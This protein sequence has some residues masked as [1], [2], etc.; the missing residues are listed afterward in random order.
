MNPRNVW[1]AVVLALGG[2]L[3]IGGMAVLK[4]DRDL[5][6]LCIVSF[7]VPVGTA[8]TAGQAA[9]NR[10]A[11]AAVQQTV[12]GNTTRLMDIIDRFGAALAAATPATA[13]PAAEPASTSTS[14]PGGGSP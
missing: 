14:S 4:V 12:N 8:L 1:P 5:I 9:E 2:M 7:M 6:L 13:E 10:A 3:I 11:T